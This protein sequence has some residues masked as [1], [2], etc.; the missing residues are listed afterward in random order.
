MV[1]NSSLSYRW[2]KWVQSFFDFRGDTKSKPRKMS[3][4]SLVFDTPQRSYLQNFVPLPDRMPFAMLEVYRYLRDNIPDLSDAVWTWKRLCNTGFIL[5]WAE[6]ISEQERERGQVV[7]EQLNR[8]MNQGEGGIATLM[9]ILYT[10]LF[11]YGAAALEIIFSA[12]GSQ[13]YDVVPVDVWT[14]RFRWEDGAWQAYQV[15]AEEVVRLPRE[16]FVYIALDRDGT[17]P[18]GRSLFRSLPSVVKVQQ[19][20]MEDMSRAMHNAGWARLHVQYKPDL[21]GTDETEEEYQ[22]RMDSNLEQIREQMSNLGIDQ[23]V[24]T[25]D[26][27]DVSVVQGAQR[28]PTYYDTQRAIEEQIITGTHTMPI[29]LGRNYGT[30]ETYG[31]VQY[32]IMNRH[33]DTINQSIAYILERI[34]RLELGLNGL[35]GG[36]S[37]QPRSNSTADALKKS[38]IETRRISTLLQLLNSNLLTTDEARKYIEKLNLFS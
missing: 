18:Y 16:R 11:T 3:R 2:W 15:H 6:T 20:L 23:N 30:T 31:T 17:N 35:H 5:K 10:S 28:A 34:Y 33:V 26:N 12:R 29:L 36:L 38:L 9:D 4:S 24:V 25:F 37:V 13:I 27:V 22:Q 19:K 14:V 8:R 32:E 21:R 1:E 7:I